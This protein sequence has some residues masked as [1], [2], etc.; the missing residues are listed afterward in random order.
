M[1]YR[2]YT[3]KPF[4]DYFIV[5]YGKKNVAAVLT[6]DDAIDTINEWIENYGK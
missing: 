2:G 6:V 5:A 1:Y 3:I 4:E